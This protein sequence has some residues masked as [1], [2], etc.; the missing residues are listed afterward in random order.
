MSGEKIDAASGQAAEP[1]PQCLPL[2]R[3]LPAPPPLPPPPPLLPPSQTAASKWA[4]A[5]RRLSKEDREQFDFANK[6][7]DDPKAVLDSVLAAT[8][9]RKDECLRKRWKLVVKGRTVI[10]RDVLEKLT[11]WIQKFMVICFSH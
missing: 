6:I 2:P 1:T 7:A 3:A 9:T 4:A 11:T 8:K 10:L 5:L